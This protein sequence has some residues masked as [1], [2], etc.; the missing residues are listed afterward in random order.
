[1]KVSAVTVARTLSSRPEVT[2]H[3]SLP[4]HHKEIAAESHSSLGVDGQAAPTD[5]LQKYN[6]VFPAP[7]DP[8]TGCTQVISGGPA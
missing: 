4:P 2:P 1:M 3:G 8:V 7:G 6:H 5:I